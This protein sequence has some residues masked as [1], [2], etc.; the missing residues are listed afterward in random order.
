MSNTLIGS[1]EVSDT[2]ASVAHQ[3]LL[4]DRCDMDPRP[5]RRCGRAP[6]RGPRRSGGTRSRAGATDRPRDRD[7]TRPCDR[8]S[9]QTCGRHR[10]PS[11]S[12]F[13]VSSPA[14]TSDGCDAPHRSADRR[15]RM[16][17]SSGAATALRGRPDRRSARTPSSRQRRDLHRRGDCRSLVRAAPSRA[18]TRATRIPAPIRRATARR[19]SR[20]SA[21]RR[22]LRALERTLGI[23]DRTHRLARDDT[24]GGEGPTVAN[25]IHLVPNGLGGI[26]AADEIGA[27]RMRF[28]TVV[29]RQRR[30]TQCLC[31]DL[32]TVQT[33]P[34]ILRSDTDVHIGSMG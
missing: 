13:P 12:W 2:V 8:D 19:A 24:A 16:R 22:R 9:P 32:S 18:R 4:R 11:P 17:A 33:T 31:D 26:A 21:T 23:Q 34:R 10:R 15:R 30:R 7:G 28:E 20:R 3:H 27:N 29:D 5:G 14:A 25:A 6:G 1:G